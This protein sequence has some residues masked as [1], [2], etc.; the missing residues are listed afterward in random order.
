MGRHNYYFN[1]ARVYDPASGR[2]LSQD[3]M[4]FDAGDSNLYRYVNNRPT[5]ATD[6]SGLQEATLGLPINKASE[7]VKFST[8]STNFGKFVK[9]GQ[10]GGVI[11]FAKAVGVQNKQPGL[12]LEYVG[13]NKDSVFFLQFMSCVTN[14]FKDGVFVRRIYDL[15]NSQNMAKKLTVQG[16]IFRSDDNE[17]RYLATGIKI[18]YSKGEAGDTQ[19]WYPDAINATGVFGIREPRDQ[20]AVSSLGGLAQDRGNNPWMFDGPTIPTRL[21]ELYLGDVRNGKIPLN[22]G[23]RLVFTLNL[24]TLLV[25]K[26]GNDLKVRATVSWSQNVEIGKTQGGN[27]EI[28]PPILGSPTMIQGLPKGEIE[29]LTQLYRENIDKYKGVYDTSFAQ[30]LGLRL[31]E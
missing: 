30:K 5:N 10:G 25:E 16:N 20:R 28:L 22:D 8:E 1:N 11:K 7:F 4:G 2:W 15:P 9:V 24:K 6:P 12:F 27:W 19:D 26:I 18:V 31:V 21:A 3:P 13:T 17:N 23:E 14:V 29:K